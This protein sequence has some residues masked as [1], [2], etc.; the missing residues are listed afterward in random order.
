MLL[1]NIDL[2]KS[3]AKIAALILVE[4]VVG[5]LSEERAAALNEKGV[6]CAVASKAQAS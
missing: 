5:D 6:V 3:I 2:R 4:P 1:V